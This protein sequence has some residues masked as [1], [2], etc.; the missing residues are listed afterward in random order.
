MKRINLVIFNE[1]FWDKGLIYTQN[2][3]PLYKLAKRENCSLRFISFTSIFMLIKERRKIIRF[4]K[5]LRS[6]GITFLIF[7]VLFYP[8]RYLILKK[9]LIPFFKLNTYI[10][11]KW[12]YINSKIN[13]L[14]YLRSYPI[15]Y[16]FLNYFKVKNKLIFDP[17]TD[18]IIE[19]INMHYFSKGS[20]TV[21]FWL[22]TEYKIISSFRNTFFIS[23][24]FRES[25]L[26]RHSIEKDI[27][28][29]RIQ[30]N[31]IESLKD[32][33]VD[34]NDDDNRK[35]FVYSGS[36][37]HWN[38]LYIYLKF[39]KNIFRFFPD[40]NFIICTSSPKQKVEIIL[41]NP[42]FIEISKNIQVFYNVS[43]QELRKIFKTCKYGLQLMSKPD[44][45]VGV[46]FIEYIAS[47]LIP[48]TNTNVLG[49][50]ELVD[51]FGIGITIGNDEEICS[52]VEK[53]KNGKNMRSLGND[54]TRLINLFN[55][56][57][58]FNYK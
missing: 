19:N 25:V 20:K 15:S 38:N 5:E 55:S 29:Y 58:A 45:R 56:E 21:E 8:T 42:E 4:L 11:V 57:M 17:R 40:S 10:Y 23:K 50:N 32:W 1:N 2:I 52:I 37:G 27:N 48:I 7:P 28:K 24:S 3:I 13:E 46:K 43:Y 6:L 34:S 22:S 39:Y 26:N 14:F 12:L 53:L 16:A 54:F 36:L 18:W 47:N 49:A 9:W 30:Y 41:S 31:T 51:E 44:T 35:D 33:I